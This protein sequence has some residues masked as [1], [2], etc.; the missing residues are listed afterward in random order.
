MS[1]LD[2]QMF[3]EVCPSSVLPFKIGDKWGALLLWCLAD[4]PRRYSEL[5]VPLARITPKVMTQSLRT[6]ERMGLVTRTVE[7]R[8]VSYELTALGRSVLEPLK[9]ICA[10]TTEH[11]EEPLDVYDPD[12][13]GSEQGLG[14]P[15]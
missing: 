2:P 4:G 6:L 11:Y 8:A 10:W 12:D 7:G 3:D 14:R 5:R 13:E 9:V 15:A 1:H